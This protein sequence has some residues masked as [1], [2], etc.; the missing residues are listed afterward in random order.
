MSEV[1]VASL[2]IA[3]AGLF[4]WAFKTLPGEGWQFIGSI[5]TTRS[6][7]GWRGV[8]FTWYGFFAATAYTVGGALFVVLM[9]S[10]GVPLLGSVLAMATVLLVCAPASSL[11]VRWVEGTRYGFTIGGASFVGLWV[12]PVVFVAIDAIAPGFGFPEACHR[13]AGGAFDCVCARGRDRPTGVHQLRM[14]LRQAGRGDSGLGAALFAPISFRVQR[15]HQEDSVRRWS[16]R[17]PSRSSAGHDC[18]GSQRSGLS[19]DRPVLRGTLQLGHSRSADDL[20]DLARLLGDTSRRLQGFRKI[21]GLSDDGWRRGSNHRW[22]SDHPTGPI[23]IAGL[24]ARR[25]G[26]SLEPRDGTRTSNRVGDPLY[27]YG[28]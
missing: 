28:P 19:S 13:R 27:L 6:D 20:A 12:A 5:P 24:P 1:F 14:L 26:R 21:H 7:A 17:R 10:V 16:R 22:R 4:Y 2:A 8:N 3:L 18:S 11:I 25:N 15:P 23:R 9:G